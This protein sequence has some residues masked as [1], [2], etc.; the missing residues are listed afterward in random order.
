MVLLELSILKEVALKEF[1]PQ[2][3]ALQQMP[4]LEVN[5]IEQILNDNKFINLKKL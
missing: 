2:L 1:V 4:T 3:H 5:E